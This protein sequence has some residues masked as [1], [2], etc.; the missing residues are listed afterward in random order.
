M[1]GMISHRKDYAEALPHIGY[2]IR[3]SERNKG[4]AKTALYMGLLEEQKLGEENILLT[5]AVDNIAS[6]RTIVALGGYLEKTERDEFY[7]ELLRLYHIAVR[8]SIKKYSE[9]YHHRI[10]IP[11]S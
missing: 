1:S 7:G 9:Q 8:H 3:P 5:C 11:N 10:F 6:N 2:G 4:Y